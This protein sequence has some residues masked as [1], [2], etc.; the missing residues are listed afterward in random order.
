MGI[1]KL[2]ACFPMV[3]R[4]GFCTEFATDFT[5]N[6]NVGA[7]LA[8]A[9]YIIRDGRTGAVVLFVTICRLFVR[10]EVRRGRV[11]YGEVGEVQCGPMMYF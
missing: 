3:L 1:A 8:I 11:R 5:N 2:L 7:L 6:R 9:I 10:G 4:L